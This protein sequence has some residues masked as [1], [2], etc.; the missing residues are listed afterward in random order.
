MQRGAVLA[1]PRHSRCLDSFDCLWVNLLW[2]DGLHSCINHGLQLGQAVIQVLTAHPH[3]RHQTHTQ[4]QP[5]QSARVH[6]A[7]ITMNC[8]GLQLLGALRDCVYPRCANCLPARQGGLFVRR[9]L[10]HTSVS[11]GVLRS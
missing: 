5:Q 7:H 8:R 10:L 1:W 9:L 6:H 4:R 2:C 11:G 3:T